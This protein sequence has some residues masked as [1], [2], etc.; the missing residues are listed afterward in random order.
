MKSNIR[1]IGVLALVVFTVFIISGCSTVQKIPIKLDPHF[2]ER[3]IDT[4][5]LMPIV[6][7]RVDKKGVVN[8]EKDL[9]LPAKKILEKRGYTVIMPDKFSEGGDIS[10]DNV[11][12]MDIADLSGLGPKESRALLFIFVEDVI[13]EYV[14]LAY[15]FKI[16]ATGSLIEKVEKVELWRDKGIGAYGQGGLISGITAG[17]DKAC[18][19]SACLE[20]MLCTIPKWEKPAPQ[21]TENSVDKAPVYNAI[22][23]S[24]EMA[25]PAI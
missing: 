4:I 11:A 19:V 16:E 25:K 17:M 7:R 24:S 23:S 9:R 12:E 21:K 3:G 13:D 15:T 18:A 8:L 20:N 2:K 1:F 14:V 5:V 22:P 10:A 6:D